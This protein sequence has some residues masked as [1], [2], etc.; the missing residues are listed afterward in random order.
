MNLL[1]F[2]QNLPAITPTGFNLFGFPIQFYGLMYL[3]AFLVSFSLSK[4]RN[5]SKKFN[6][7]NELLEEFYF[8]IIIA[9]ILGGRFGYILFYNLEYF[10]Q[11]PLEAIIP[12]KDGKYIG[13]AG[14]SFHGGLLTAVT[15]GIF[16]LKSKKINLL[17]FSDLVAPTIPIAYM[18]GRIGNFLNGELY[19]RAS[20]F[21]LSMKFDGILRHP[22]AL[23]EAFFEGFILYLIMN[24][25]KDQKLYEG[26]LLLVFIVLYS[27]FRFFIEFV[28]EPD[29]HIGLFLGF[30]RGQYLCI[31]TII[32]ALLLQRVLRKNT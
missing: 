12:F 22:S 3:V 13:I 6:F 11:N 16:Y 23:Y 29:S 5:K 18:F 27:I 8:V 28:R 14:M 30:S 32:A 2:W 25:I 19:G 10:I 20:N 7:E 1:D 17:K 9:I 15:A 31:V 26:K 24:K 21:V 4:K